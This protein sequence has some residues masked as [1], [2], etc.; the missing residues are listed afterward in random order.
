MI[1]N[2][3]PRFFMNHSV[4][5]DSLFLNYVTFDLAISV[6]LVHLVPV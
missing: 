5:P 3:L 4:S 6:M 1:T 2:V